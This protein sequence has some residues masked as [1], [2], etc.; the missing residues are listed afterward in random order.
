MRMLQIGSRTQEEVED[1]LDKALV[2]MWKVNA[3]EI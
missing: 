1:K 2:Y 3:A